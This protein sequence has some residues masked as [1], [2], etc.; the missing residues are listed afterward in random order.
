MALRFTQRDFLGL[1]EE[2]IRFMSEKLGDKWN[3]Y[4]ESDETMMLI[5]LLAHCVSNLHFAYDNQ[6]R[7]TDIVTASFPRNVY[8]HAIRNGYKPSLFKAGRTWINIDLRKKVDG[9]VTNEYTTLPVSV[10]IPRYTEI[11]NT[12]GDIC[13]TNR[14][15]ILPAGASHFSIEVLGGQYA[16]EQFTRNDINEF[17]YIVLGRLNVSSDSTR[18]FYQNEEW[19][20]VTDVYTDIRT[21]KIYSLEP[22]FVRQ[23]V[24]NIIRFFTN[25][26]DE[27]IDTSKITLEYI[28]TNGSMSNYEKDTFTSYLTKDDYS[29]NTVSFNEDVYD[30]AGNKLSSWTDVDVSFTQSK[31]FENGQNYEA[32][33][34][35]KKSYIQ[36]L[37]QTTSLVVLEDYEA[38]LTLNG[39]ND[40]YVTDWDRNKI[41]TITIEY[42]KDI[43]ALKA[44]PD[45]YGHDIF[46]PLNTTT[47]PYWQQNV[48]NINA[49]DQVTE[50]RKIDGREIIIFKSFDVNIDDFSEYSGEHWYESW[51]TATQIK[52]GYNSQ[53]GISSAIFLASPYK[54]YLNDKSILLRNYDDNNCFIDVSSRLRILLK[55]FIDLGG[56]APEIRNRITCTKKDYSDVVGYIDED[57][58]NSYPQ[59][60]NVRYGDKEDTRITKYYNVPNINSLFKSY[61]LKQS[62]SAIMF[63]APP[64]FF[65]QTTIVNTNV[66]DICFKLNNDIYSDL[67]LE[68]IKNIYPSFEEDIINKKSYIYSSLSNKI[69]SITIK[70][71]GISTP[72]SVPSSVWN[73]TFFIIDGADT[74]Y[75]ENDNIIEYKDRDGNNVNFK[76][77]IT[78]DVDSIYSAI[79]YK[80]SQSISSLLIDNQ[81]VDKNGMPILHLKKSY[82]SDESITINS[83]IGLCFRKKTLDVHPIFGTSLGDIKPYYDSNNKVY[84][85]GNAG[86]LEYFS[87]EELNG[88]QITK[89]YISMPVFDDMDEEDLKKTN[90]YHLRY[91]SSVAYLKGQSSSI[92]N[93]NVDKKAYDVFYTDSDNHIPLI[94]S[95]DDFYHDDFFYDSNQLTSKPLNL[96]YLTSV[97]N[98]NNNIYNDKSDIFYIDDYTAGFCSDYNLEEPESF[99]PTQPE[100]Q[101]DKY[102]FIRTATHLVGDH[103]LDYL[104]FPCNLENENT[105]LDNETISDLNDIQNYI[106]NSILIDIQMSFPKYLKYL[107]LQIC[108]V[109]EASY[110]QTHEQLNKYLVDLGI[111]NIKY[112][113]NKII[114]ANYEI[115][116]WY[117]DKNAKIGKQYTYS[118]NENKRFIACGGDTSWDEDLSPAS[119]YFRWDIVYPEIVDL[120]KKIQQKQGRG[121]AV[122]ILP[123]IRNSID[124]HAHVFVD[125]SVADVSSVFENIW[126]AIA[127]FLGILTNIDQTHYVSEFI[128]VIQSADTSILKVCTVGE[129]DYIGLYAVSE[130]DSSETMF[131]T[132]SSES[133]LD[134]NEFYRFLEFL[135]KE[136]VEPDSDLG[137]SLVLGNVVIR[138]Q[139]NSILDN[140]VYHFERN[141][142]NIGTTLAYKLKQTN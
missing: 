79:G 127:N 88:E 54:R 48:A 58:F 91:L 29:E 12:D 14:E 55:D 115:A 113:L 90:A 49:S 26:E 19:T 107:I 70:I 46:S 126:N 33:D 93:Y 76:H 51:K 9:K 3:D 119:N 123:Y 135:P 92:K 136:E 59:H 101:N 110:T 40:F 5:E 1:R 102:G 73:D 104:S 139:K 13:I 94:I 132:D 18:M 53:I 118:P 87:S 112:A 105:G 125:S 122:F 108:F 109:Y 128:S 84:K 95:T 42:P 57:T 116:Y 80:P 140:M 61:Y 69:R 120:Y 72:F 8:A 30:S 86:T 7:E 25:W 28:Q 56:D 89:K 98:Q 96:N 134:Q 68:D 60:L 63:D 32:V 15:F 23:G 117:S 75:D 111:D 65:D 99:D 100:I 62:H 124:I 41:E 106:N 133:S 24:R 37:R 44:E 45:E 142:M 10:T 27:I 85:Y 43:K 138:I 66:A 82:D 47:T 103:K 35:I 31:P 36:S 131:I 64:A 77:G 34:V 22:N 6:K 81:E 129:I 2:M 97:L 17:N 78:V 141:G 74:L 21:S 130:P 71:D 38:L 39:I 4:S 114:S 137:H 50:T 20:P 83:K 52:E 11:K 121:D 67:F 16:Y